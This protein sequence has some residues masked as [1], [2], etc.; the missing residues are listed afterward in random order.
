MGYALTGGSD[1]TGITTEADITSLTVTFTAISSRLYRTTLDANIQQVTSGST[2]SLIITDGAGTDLGLRTVTLATSDLYAVRMAIVE[3]GLS[4]SVT[5]KA[6]A[7]T[8]AGTLSIIN[9][10]SRNGR[11]VVEDIGP[12]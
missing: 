7:V 12:A 6:R 9:S 1:Q 5:R 11:I 4:G 8:S 2:P 3:T 10:L